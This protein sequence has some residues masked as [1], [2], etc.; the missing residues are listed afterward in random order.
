MIFKDAMG[1]EH[2]AFITKN[3]K[4]EIIVSAGAIGSPQLLMLSGIGPAEQLKAHGIKMVLDQPI[5]GL[6]MA[7]NP[8]NALFVPSPSPVE[9]SLIQVVGITKF[10][11]YVEAASGLDFAYFWGQMLSRDT[12]VFVNQVL[13]SYF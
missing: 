8:M 4:N 6:G 9:M 11:S 3:S 5:V 1:V 2:R 7:D 10:G 12:G 13:T